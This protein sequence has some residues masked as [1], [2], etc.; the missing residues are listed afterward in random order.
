M[1]TDRQ[2]FGDL[3]LMA[4]ERVDSVFDVENGL[5]SDGQ[6]LSEVLLLTN[7]R[8]IHLNGRRDRRQAVF[9]SLLNVDAVEV[10]NQPQ[11]YGAFVWAGLALLVAVGVWQ[12]WDHPLKPLAALLVVAMGVYLVVDRLLFPGNAYAVVNAG[13]SQLRLKINSASSSRDIY[14]LVNRLF[15]LQTEAA[16]GAA[17][18]AVRFPPR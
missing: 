11:G 16:N 4:D 5:V 15:Q 7:R 10:T 6:D 3:A 17:P 2:G 14:E 18:G 12:A 1:E 13:P 8:V 9:V